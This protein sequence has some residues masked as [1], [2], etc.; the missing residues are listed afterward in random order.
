MSGTQEKGKAME[1]EAS[2]DRCKNRYSV[3]CKKTD[4]PVVVYGTAKE[5]AEAIGVSVRSFYRYISR[6]REGKI[7]SRK[8]DVYEDGESEEEN[9]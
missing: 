6:I 3:Y 7:R 2:R 4:M 5:C 9:E 8:W 1:N